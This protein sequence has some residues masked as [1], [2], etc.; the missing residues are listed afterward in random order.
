[1]STVASSSAAP[2][3]QIQRGRF[4]RCSRHAASC[5]PCHVTMR[6]TCVDWRSLSHQSLRITKLAEIEPVARLCDL[7]R[8]F[9]FL[10]SSSASHICFEPGLRKEQV[11]ERRDQV[12]HMAACSM[13]GQARHEMNACSF[14][15]LEPLA[16]ASTVACYDEC[17]T[18]ACLLAIVSDTQLCETSIEMCPRTI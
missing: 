13:M 7:V 18:S 16:K 3:N 14:F 9:M 4:T 15:G 8:F 12:R 17:V 2:C 6:Y 11:N 10:C 1:M 5:K